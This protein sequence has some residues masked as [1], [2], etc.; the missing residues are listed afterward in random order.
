[1]S[2]VRTFAESLDAAL[3]ARARRGDRAAFAAIYSQYERAAF[4][5]ALRILGRGVE[6]EDAV[7]DAFVRAFEKISGYRGDA[8]FGA[9]IKRLVANAAIDRLRRERRWRED[10][11]AL[12]SLPQPASSPSASMDATSLF[13]RLPARARSVVWLHEMEGYSHAEI[14]AMFRQSESWSKSLLARSL[15]ALRERLAEPNT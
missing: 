2:D 6:A 9:W 4:G 10:D 14:G 5:L 7:H 12:E 15:A 3:L 1:M 11:D 13:D 8:P